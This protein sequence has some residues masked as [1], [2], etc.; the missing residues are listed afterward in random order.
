LVVSDD[1]GRDPNLFTTRWTLVWITLGVV[2]WALV[3]WGL[4]EL[5]T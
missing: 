2:F 1:D 3:T 5:L 4:V